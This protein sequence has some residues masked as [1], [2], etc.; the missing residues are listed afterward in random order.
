MS[1]YETSHRRREDFFL[2][3]FFG[4]QKNLVYQTFGGKKRAQTPPPPPLQ[5]KKGP[6]VA[7]PAREV[8]EISSKLGSVG[9]VA[10]CFVGKSAGL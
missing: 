1:H 5:V 8:R 3:L 9:T 4:P 2:C 6:K 10:I 7:P